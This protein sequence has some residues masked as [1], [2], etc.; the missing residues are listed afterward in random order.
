M[1]S[2]TIARLAALALL[3]TLAACTSLAWEGAYAPAAKAS[4]GRAV[5][6]DAA[7]GFTAG[8]M[9]PARSD[10]AASAARKVIR[11]ADLRLDVD[12]ADATGREIVRVANESGGFV[13]SSSRLRYQIKV[14]AGGLDSAVERIESMGELT[15]RAFHGED[16]TAEYVDLEVRLKNA[17]AAREAYEALLKKA[18]TVE[19]MLKVEQALHE[20]QERIE[21][22]AG[23]RKYLDDHLALSDIDV[24]LR[25]VETPGPLRV[26]W[27]GVAW[28]AKLLW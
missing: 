1:T 12:D 24:S 26:L 16:V 8:A 11:S 3:P 17:H 13:L 6:H 25:E 27:N 23:R 10:G 15:H 5:A 18:A 22:L 28:F 2:R 9:E 20:V 7:A 4:M 14:P 21:L 19:E